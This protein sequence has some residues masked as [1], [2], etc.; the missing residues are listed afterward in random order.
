MSRRT[1]RITSLIQTELSEV[2]LKKLKD[3][4]IGFVT[5]TGVDV[6][7]DLKFA[8]VYYSVLGKENEKKETQRALE[9]ASGFLQHEIAEALKLRFTPKLSFHLDESLEEGMRIER[10]LKEIHRENDSNA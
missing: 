10:I 7:P 4:R 2:V 6:T 3:P 9:R 8:Q 1:E 5:L